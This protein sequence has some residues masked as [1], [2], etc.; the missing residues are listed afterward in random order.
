MTE[1]W[2]EHSQHATVDD[3]MLD[4]NSE[5]IDKLERP[6]VLKLLGAVEGKRLLELGAGIGRFTGDLARTAK[7]VHAVDFMQSFTDANKEANSKHKNVTV[8]CVDATKAAYEGN[9]FDVVFSNWLLMYLTDEEIKT[10][11]TSILT[12]LDEGGVFFFRESCFQQSG[13]RKR[14]KNPTQ[15]R[16]PQE[17]FALF[18][19][20]EATLSDGKIGSFKFEFCRSIDSYVKLK[21]NQYQLCWKLTKV[22][23]DTK[24]DPGFRNF[25]DTSQYSRNGILRYER[26]FGE[27]FV[28]TGGVDTTKEFIAQL[29]LKP[30]Q[31]V[32]DIGC[33]IGGGDFLMADT[34][35][36]MV[37]GMDLSVNMVSIAWERAAGRDDDRVTFEIADCTTR[38]YGEESFD[39]IYSRDTILHIQDKPAL[40][41]LFYKFLKPGGKL[42]IT[43][44]CRSEGEATEDFKAYIK[45]R[46][47]DLHSPS[48]YGKMIEG[49]GF[50]D[51]VATDA[52]DKFEASLRKELALVE[53]QKEEYIKD[54]SEKDYNDIV[55]GWNAKLG[56]LDQQRWGFFTARKADDD[57]S[58]DLITAKSP[59]APS[60]ISPNQAFQVAQ[61]LLIGAR[62]LVQG[63]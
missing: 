20:A 23:S 58:M 13:D 53:G 51:V 12:W 1:F 22:V 33:G 10:L 30:E 62:S 52:T 40:F 39:V 28:S 29:D 34:Y 63:A 27:G 44:Y 9:T 32:L 5:A 18:D 8:E 2:V 57:Q 25:L 11:A 24:T 3:M 19:A 60:R 7:A 21:H 36:C 59:V 47:Y 41:K 6:E 35:G 45:Q 56:R 26:I 31:S 15:Y 16:K 4:S 17:Y 55:S 38:D 61:E 43:D 42:M 46:G 50:V 37:H 54:F 48:Q 14:K 49:A